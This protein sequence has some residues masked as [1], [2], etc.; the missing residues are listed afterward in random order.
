V[1][2]AFSNTLYDSIIYIYLLQKKH[3]LVTK[4]L[5]DDNYF[6]ANRDAY[7]QC[8][9]VSSIL[10][11]KLQF[12]CSISSH[13]SYSVDGILDIFSHYIVESNLKTLVITSL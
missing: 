4:C 6:D 10:I 8:E 2:R 12:Q 9:C 7:I 1:V 5:D 13:F 11:S 3:L